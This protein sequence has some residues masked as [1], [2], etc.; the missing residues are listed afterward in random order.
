MELRPYVL[1]HRTS[2]T[3]RWLR[4]RRLKL[5]LWLAVAEGIL[6]VFDVIPG[7]TAL[8]AAAVVV[9]LYLFV[10]RQVRSDTFR[11]VTWIAAA[12]QICVAL[13]PVVAFIV[14]AL[15]LIVVAIL[16]LIAAAALFADR[17]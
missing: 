8:L 17:R 10:G 11:Q 3:G 6:V 2:R 15:A 9:A 16:A 13:V 14:G 1:D 12:S 5:A 7:W 4:A